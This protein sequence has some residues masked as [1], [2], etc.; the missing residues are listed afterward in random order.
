MKHE[1]KLIYTPYG[2]EWKNSVMKMNKINIIE[3]LKR[4]CIKR[5]ELEKEI[6]EIR[7]DLYNSI[8]GNLGNIKAGKI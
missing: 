2:D 4:V 5:D 8:N 3:M 7:D 1:K 6:E